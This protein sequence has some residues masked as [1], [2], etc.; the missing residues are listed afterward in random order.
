MTRTAPERDDVE[1]NRRSWDA[2]VPGHLVAYGAE[3]FAADP[4]RISSVVRDDLVAM[5]P[6][7]PGGSPEGLDLVHLQ[8]HIGLDTLS[9]AR[10][11]A[12]VTGVDFSPAATAAARDLARRAGLDASFVDS[13]VE[14]AV[15]ACGRQFDV[16]YTGIGAL[17]WLP[18]LAGWART[19]AG[20]L[21]P[22][23]VFHVRDA[24]PV[25]QALDQDR[26][27]GALVL[28]QPY[29]AGPPQRFD[30]A[31][32]YAGAAVPEDA[33]TT[34]EWQHPVSEVVQALLDAG[35]TL[36]ALAEGRTI[37]WPALP[38]MVRD[39]A[40][41]ALPEGRDRLP[42]TFSLTATRPR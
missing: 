41:W 16:V 18:D 27:D 2:V 34:V 13:D 29:F 22:G 23:G 35:L 31:T 11:G 15:A 37:P 17:C 20:L 42:L 26:T 3:E 14:G 39:G 32:T 8:C 9:W 7:L 36:V 12:R 5:A 21:R 19:V 1:T 33:A 25:L 24:H 28:T 10:L 30:H 40:S 6:H 4:A 38:G